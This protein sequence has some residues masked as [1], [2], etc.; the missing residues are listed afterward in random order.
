MGRPVNA[1]AYPNGD[2]DRRVSDACARAGYRRGY[3]A[4]AG[5]VGVDSDVW[6]LP[7]ILIGGYDSARTLTRRINEVACRRVVGRA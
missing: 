3:A 7:R 1:I 6:Q 4:R 5:L 2:S